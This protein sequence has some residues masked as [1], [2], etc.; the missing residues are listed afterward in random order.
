MADRIF[1]TIETTVAPDITLS[2]VNTQGQSITTYQTGLPQV[3]TVIQN[4]VLPVASI[5]NAP[6]VEVTSVNGMTGDVVTEPIMGD[7]QPNH[8]YIKNTIINNGGALYWAKNTFTSGSTFNASDWNLVSVSSDWSDITNKP[9]I[10][11]ATLTIQQNGSSL[12]TFTANATSNKSID[13]EAPIRKAL[14][15]TDN[16]FVRR[17]IGLCEVSPNANYQ[18]ISYGIGTIYFKRH[19]GL[20]GAGRLEIHMDNRYAGTYTPNYSYFSTIPLNSASGDINTSVGWRP[21]VFKY[22]DVWYG[23][24]EV[25]LNTADSGYIWFEGE[26][27]IDVFAVDYYKVPHGST[28]ATVVNQEV[29]DSLDY[30]KPVIDE[31]KSR[32][33]ANVLTTVT[34]NITKNDTYTATLPNKTGTLA[35]T[36]DIPT[37]PTQTSAFTNNGSDGTSTYV[38]ATDL[39]TVAT[40]GSYTDL[41][42]IPTNLVYWDTISTTTT[43]P[44][45]GSSVIINGSV[46]NDKLAG[47]ITNAKLAGGITYDKLTNSSSTDNGWTKVQLTSNITMWFKYGSY[48]KTWSATQWTS[49]TP[50]TKPTTLNTSFPFTGSVSVKAN[51]NAINTSGFINSSGSV[52]IQEYN[53]YSGSVTTTAYYNAIIIQ[54][55]T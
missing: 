54:V 48:S 6:F 26:S 27:N 38:E 10:G 37:I 28:A 23:G 43:Q 5:I 4:G 17:V 3:Q 40:S 2:T 9:T 46:T 45:V 51:D 39:A 50:A 30:T 22:N 33:R 41:I 13:I 11:N 44:W 29:Y 20:S 52:V 55:M 32:L 42:N 19:N 15:A 16:S 18:F 24:V 1:G 49:S 12:G 34:G 14:R 47:G 7:F 8:Y 36:S 31:T 25:M 21:C 53:C 35:M